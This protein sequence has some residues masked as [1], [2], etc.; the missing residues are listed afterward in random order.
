MSDRRRIDLF[1]RRP[2]LGGWL[3]FALG[4]AVYW[5]SLGGGYVW[6]DVPFIVD[7]PLLLDENG[8][9][10]LWFSDR[11]VDYW[12]VSYSTFWLERRL[13]GLNPFVSHVVNV[14][15]HGLNAWLLWRILSR[16]GLHG[17]W[18]AALLFL[19]HPLGVD[20]VANIFQRKTLLAAT[21]SLASLLVWLRFDERGGTWRY[22]A[23]LFLFLLAVLS[24]SS[25]LMLP[26]VLLALDVWRHRRLR[27]EGMVR[28]VPFFAASLLLGLVGLQFQQRHMLAPGYSPGD[29]LARFANIGRILLFYLSKSIWP[30]ELVFVYPRW[31][32]GDR[33]ADLPVAV[34]WSSIAAIV[35]FLGWRHRERWGRGLL[36]A[37]ACYLAA[38]FPVLG[39]VDIVYFR[40]SWVADRFHYL[41][42]PV[43][44]GGAVHLLHLA[45]ARTGQG[46]RLALIVIAPIALI[47]GAL[48]WRQAATF[49]SE[50]QVWRHQI[51]L[52]P[53]SWTGYLNLGAH[54]YRLGRTEEAGRLLEKALVLAPENPLVHYDLGAMAMARGDE[55]AARRHY[56]AALEIDPDFYFANN[57]LG[58][59]LAS[60]GELESAER[61]LR[62]A[63]RA[64]PDSPAVLTNL[65][66][67]LLRQRRFAEA[68]RLLIR[69]LELEP[70]L[71]EALNNLAAL[72]EATDRR[73]E[74]RIYLD[75]ARSLASRL[76]NRP[77]ARE[78][79]AR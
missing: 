40:F 79:R 66:G 31:Q 5:P 37:V 56:L 21:F 67:L 48:S 71:P 70:E 76:R 47:L 32:T 9:F 62:A 51:A 65:G 4:L 26:P 19:L 63:L 35:A 58:R 30:N 64:V 78:S 20:A 28:L 53:D 29:A 49:Q 69:A 55:S 73:G 36:L 2:A 41:A 25:A 17:A 50:E 23:S 77:D 68:E 14:L 38:L 52:Q 39:L 7:N 54:L 42:M 15:L 8:L 27:P 12:P 57:N 46:S 72:M 1:C 74:A 13:L 59:L 24:K 61:Y 22:L 44:A 16:L 11:P 43:L 6:D 33:S 10:Q 34:L 3:L 75:K 45:L 60:R 18:P